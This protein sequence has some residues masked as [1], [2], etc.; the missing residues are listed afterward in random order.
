MVCQIHTSRHAV[1]GKSELGKS[2]SLLWVLFKNFTQAKTLSPVVA[3]TTFFQVL[4]VHTDL[5]NSANKKLYTAAL[6]ISDLV[7]NVLI[8]FAQ[9]A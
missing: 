8:N 9:T 7:K 6:W 1:L 5:I 4:P 3:E 2:A